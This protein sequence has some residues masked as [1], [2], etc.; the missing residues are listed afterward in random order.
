MFL[1]ALERF[2]Q[3][4]QRLPAPRLRLIGEVRDAADHDV[5]LRTP[6]DGDPQDVRGHQQ[7]VVS[8]AVRLRRQL[9]ERACASA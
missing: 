4:A 3:S 1:L 6:C 2:E 5:A 9:Q 7:E 8:I